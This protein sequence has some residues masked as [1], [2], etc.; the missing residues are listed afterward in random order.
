MRTKEFFKRIGGMIGI[1]VL[2]FLCWSTAFYALPWMY[3]LLHVSDLSRFAEQIIISFVGFFIFGLIMFA[4]S[5]I[6]R[7]RERQLR[8]F[9]PII[10]AMEK[11]ARGNFN[12]DLSS[13]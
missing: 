3:R 4:I 5:H 8:F 9:H 11:M 10:E 2:L 13:Y 7:I 6:G 12:I 1:M